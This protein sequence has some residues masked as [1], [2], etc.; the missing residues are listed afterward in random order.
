MCSAIFI[1]V[2]MSVDLPA[3]PLP[4]HA[5][6]FCPL[7]TLTPLDPCCSLVL[8]RVRNDPAIPQ[9]VTSAMALG[10]SCYAS[11]LSASEPDVLVGLALKA[12]A[13]LEQCSKAAAE[14]GAKG[15]STDQTP[16]NIGACLSGE[17]GLDVRL[18]RF[19][20]ACLPCLSV[21]SARQLEYSA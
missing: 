19:S 3:W 8:L 5:F 14:A 15:A 6:A 7:R 12:V 11:S 9:A 18:L 13:M 4:L 10:W 20:I 1:L 21:T 16:H 2:K 17:R